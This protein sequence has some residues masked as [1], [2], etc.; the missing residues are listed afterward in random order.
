MSK[1]GFEKLATTLTILK[2]NLSYKFFENVLNSSDNTA[3]FMRERDT[4]L[5][6]LFTNYSTI[7]AAQGETKLKDN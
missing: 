7:V 4:S 3:R 5:Q 2:E 1:L 6:I